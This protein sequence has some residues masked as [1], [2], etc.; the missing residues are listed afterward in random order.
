MHTGK[1]I[2]ILFHESGRRIIGRYA[3]TWLADY[4]RASGHKVIFLFGTGNFVP[5]DAVIV[6]VDLSVVPDAYLEF[7]KHY[8][9]ALNAGIRDIRKS[10]VSPN[11]IRRGE[12]YKGM[13]IVKTDLN[14]G[15]MPEKYAARP[16][17]LYDIR[18]ALDKIRLRPARRARQLPQRMRSHG[19]SVYESLDQV[20]GEIMKS[21][22]YVIEKFL[23]EFENNLYHVR[24]MRFLG[25]GVVCTRV[26]S[27]YPIVRETNICEVREEVEPHPDMVK[28]VKEMGMEYGKIDYVMHEGRPVVI[29]VNKT[30]GGG[31]PP[32]SAAIENSRRIMASGLYDYL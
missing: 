11:L 26:G 23:P 4:W 10:T 17:L 32:V 22:R 21:N 30:T 3:I 7:A 8:P 12:S 18:A 19:Y 25:S 14:S 28:F 2:A 16:K 27:T 9:I 13:V 31:P 24:N 5:A 20:P 6:H 29:D 15:G 1:T